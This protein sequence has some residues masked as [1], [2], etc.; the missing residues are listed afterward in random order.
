[1]NA[2]VISNIKYSG[3]K[4]MPDKE[5]DVIKKILPNILY[6]ELDKE[7]DEEE[8]KDRLANAIFDTTSHYVKNFEYDDARD[9]S[10]SK[11]NNAME[12][13]SDFWCIEFECEKE[14]I[15]DKFGFGYSEYDENISYLDGDNISEIKVPLDEICSSLFDLTSASE[16]RQYIFWLY[17]NSN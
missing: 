6:I 17:E 11:L 1:M 3:K 15:V 12:E 4:Q 10:V 16:I 8:I 9:W 2:Y 7:C 5:N 14:D 13:E